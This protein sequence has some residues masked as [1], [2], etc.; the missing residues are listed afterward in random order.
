MSR[1]INVYEDLESIE[2][3]YFEFYINNQWVPWSYLSD[4]TKRIFYLITEVTALRNNGVALIE[5]PELGVHPH[6]LHLL[7]QFLKEQS[8]SK[9]IIITTHSPQVLN[10]LDA[11]ELNR[12]IIAEMIDNGTQLKH[13]DERRIEKARSYMRDEAYLS[14]YWLHS[15]L[16]SRSQ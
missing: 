14:D 9:Q 10:V 2:N 8:E 6:Q 1:N 15:D 13:L 7:T 12:I 3:I 5:E 4:G 11:D 16:E